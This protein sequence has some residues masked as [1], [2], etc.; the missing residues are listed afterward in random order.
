MIKSS[1][2]DHIL[3]YWRKHKYITTK[4][5]AEE[6]GILRLASR[7]SDM[8]KRGYQIGDEYIPVHDRYGN[9]THIKRYWLMEGNNE[10]KNDI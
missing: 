1:Q 3:E 7:I 6:L 8:R 9:K 4:T 10:Q 5:A 2:C